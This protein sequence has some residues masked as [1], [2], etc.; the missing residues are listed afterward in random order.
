[1]WLP[2]LAPSNQLVR[3]ALEASNDREWRSF[4]RKYRAEMKRPSAARLLDVLAALSHQTN[5]SVGCYCERED[6]C[7]RAV[8]RVLLADRGARFA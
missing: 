5:F 1:V 2:E 6:R 4:V 7:H 8:L 3:A